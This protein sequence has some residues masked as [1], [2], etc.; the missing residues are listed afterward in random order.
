[1]NKKTTKQTSAELETLSLEFLG[2]VSGAAKSGSN[3]RDPN[4]FTTYVHPRTVVVV[5]TVRVYR[6]TPTRSRR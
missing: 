4:G 1:M 3:P 5:K 6:G 2:Q